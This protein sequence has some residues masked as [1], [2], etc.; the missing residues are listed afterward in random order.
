MF[1]RYVSSVFSGRILQLCLSECC[2]CFTHILY[3]FYSDVA[4][5]GNG[6]QVCFRC[7]FQVF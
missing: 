1:Q 3:V 7:V 2:I 4:Y 6:F 5:S